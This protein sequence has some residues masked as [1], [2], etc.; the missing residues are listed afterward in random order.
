[1]HG[2]NLLRGKEFQWGQHD[3]V[4]LA[5]PQ[6]AHVEPKNI[7]V[8]GNVAGQ[9]IDLGKYGRLGSVCAIWKLEAGQSL[10]CRR[11]DDATPP[12][13]CGIPLLHLKPER[14]RCGATTAPAVSHQSRR[15]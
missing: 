9:R 1:M 12:V 3:E 2:P 6:R 7:G 11:Y 10:L 14:G 8:L 15:R 4:G 5:A 13:K